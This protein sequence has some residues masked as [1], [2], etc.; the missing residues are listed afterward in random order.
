MKKTI[1]LLIVLASLFTACKDPF[2]NSEYLVRTGEDLSLSN[3]EY[4]SKYPEK[5]SKWVE[6]LKYADMFNAMNDAATSSTVFAPDN[7]AMDKFL[8]WKGIKS[9]QELDKQYAKYVVQVHIIKGII[10]NNDFIA[11]VNAGSIPIKTVFGSYLTTSYGYKITDVDDNLRDLSIHDSLSIYLNNQAKVASIGSGGAITANGII[12]TVKDVIRPLSE[13][14]IDRLRVY[15]D[16]YSIF[17]KA[18]EIT[19]YEKVASVYADTVSNL[20]G[21]ISI[22]QIRNTCFAVP[23][24]VYNDAGIKSVEDLESYLQ[25]GSDF[26][27]PANAFYK[28]MAYHFLPQSFNKETLSKFKVIGEVSLYDT[29]LQGNIITVNS[30]NGVL[31]INNLASVLRSNIEARN[32]VIHKIDN[33]LPIYSPKPIRVAWDFCNAPDIESF[34]NAYGA[35]NKVG[36]LF[37]TPLTN[38]E[39]QIDLSLDHLQG[40]F[41]TLTSFQYVAS[42]SKTPAQSYRKVGFF[43]CAYVSSAQ[44]TVNTYGANMD[45]LMIL[46][47]GYTGYITLKTPTIIKGKYKVVLYYA[48]SPGLKTFYTN[49]SNT[50]FNLDDY[51]KN[52]YMWKG[53]PGTFVDVTKRT[54]SI[55]N[56]IAADVLWDVVEFPESGTHT[57]KATILDINAKTNSTYRQM[58]DYM[59]FIP[60]EQ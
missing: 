25:A 10:S 4:F 22:N 41:G 14:I 44:N 31:K 33:I 34:V 5:Y 27:S 8:Q 37:S 13:T 7:D 55:A 28:Y 43:K 39:T 46:N 59:E 51:Q 57:L 38:K 26:A 50:R 40:N 56:G 29:K 52:L 16:E 17:I 49:G 58:W 9:I 2:L 48:G 24:K 21:S 23:D 18:A 60:L 54:N 30:D 35:T 45:N 3:A 32:G 20:D 1:I 36:D 11:D 19:G 53:L 15:K 47:L 42:T 6:L 12:Y